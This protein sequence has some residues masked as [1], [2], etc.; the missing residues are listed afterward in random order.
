MADELMIPSRFR[1]PPD[2]AN[3]GYACGLVAAGLP[4]GS[5]AEVTLR[6]PPPLDHTL[7]LVGAGEEAELRD[8]ETLV[9]AA[10][11]IDALD[12][13]IPDP[14]S[15]DAARRAR[16][17]SPLQTEHPYPT[18]FVCGPQAQDGLGVTCGHVAG[19]DDVVAAPFGTAEW[20]AG[21]GDEV[22][23][24]FAWAALDCPGGIAGMLE[25]DLGVTVLGRLAAEF[26][27]PIRVGREYVAIGWNEG[28][29]GRKA[30]AGSA[31]LDADGT[32]LALGRATW[33]EVRPAEAG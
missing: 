2:S 30:A 10:R 27:E 23:P 11:A 25:P 33:I 21:P 14:V 7:E 31:I 4:E 13:S 24:E 28:R 32:P 5:I 15:P 6:A 16:D 19:R 8:G 22:R 1:G 3:G 17:G 29:D 26:R 18:C 9:A 20:M 12:V